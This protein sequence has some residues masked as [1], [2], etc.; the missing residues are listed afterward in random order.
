[1]GQ[2]PFI[3]DVSIWGESIPALVA[4]YLINDGKNQEAINE[5][6]PYLVNPWDA[7][8]EFFMA[9]AFNNLGETDSALHYAQLAHELKPLYFRNLHMML[10]I[11]ED[12]GEKDDIPEYLDTFLENEKRE[13]NAW[14]YS[15]GFHARD[16]KFDKAYDL[17]KEAARYFPN[18]SLVK[19]Q[20]RYI[21]HHK[22]ILPNRDLLSRATTLY[23]SQKYAEA[24]EA[25]NEYIALVPEDNTAYRVRAFCHYHTQA[26]DECLS[27]INHFFEVQ[28]IDGSLLNLRGVCLRAQGD[29][30]AA[31]L[32]FRRAMNMGIENARTNYQRFCETAQ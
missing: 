3:P 5:L 14:I 27:D 28:G 12:K 13:L 24:I 29:L 25:F 7:R 10:R 17:I 32:D 23:T 30:E 1:V 20:H 18:D 11:L 19:Q 6:R 16:G 2:F 22:F 8:R 26:Y 15:T 4:R 31:C 21:Y 9:T